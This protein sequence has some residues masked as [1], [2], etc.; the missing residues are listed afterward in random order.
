MLSLGVPQDV[1]PFFLSRPFTDVLEREREREEFCHPHVPSRSDR[2]IESVTD[3]ATGRMGSDPHD[4]ASS[5]ND[6][7]ID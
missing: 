7:F 2:P 6:E 3:V 1:I 4:F 5:Q